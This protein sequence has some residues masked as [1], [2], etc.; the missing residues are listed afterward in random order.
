MQT[1]ISQE[2]V[3]VDIHWALFVLTI[4]LETFKLYFICNNEEKII[5]VEGEVD[6]RRVQ[7]SITNIE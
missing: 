4:E 1:R 3:E 7:I 6:T 5:M 2:V